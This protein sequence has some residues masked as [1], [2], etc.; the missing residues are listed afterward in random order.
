MF[1]I[2]DGCQWMNVSS[3]TDPFVSD[4]PGGSVPPTRVVPDK[5]QLNGCV[6]IY[7]FLLLLTQM[8]QTI[9]G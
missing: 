9:T 2:Q 5:G 4:Y 8:Q 3:G 1:D 7:Q 6:C